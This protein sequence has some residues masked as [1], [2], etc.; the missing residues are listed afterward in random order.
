[1]VS[2]TMQLHS[3]FFFFTNYNQNKYYF[4]E[5]M[6]I[7]I[8]SVFKPGCEFLDEA[9]LPS[10]SPKVLNLGKGC[11]LFGVGLPLDY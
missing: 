4:L 3:F 5:E 8:L 10:H 2:L 1:M 7:Y 6:L 9:A 11:I